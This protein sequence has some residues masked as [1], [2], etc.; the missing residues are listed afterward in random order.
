[1][2][3]VLSLLAPSEKANSSLTS[4][5]HLWTEADSAL[6][7]QYS[8]LKQRSLEKVQE[9]SGGLTVDKVDNVFSGYRLYQ[10]FES[11]RRFENHLCPL[12]SHHHGLMSDIRP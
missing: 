12:H 4:A 5:V 7:T 8:I 2:Y 10:A 1:M 9:R 11:Y 6:E 3:R